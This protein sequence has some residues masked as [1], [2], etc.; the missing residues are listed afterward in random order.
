MITK[1]ITSLTVTF[2]PLTPRSA[3]RTPRLLLSLLPPAARRPGG[4]V[5]K[6]SIL[7]TSAGVDAPSS[8]TLAFRDGKE[9]KFL[10]VSRPAAKGGKTGKKVEGEVPEGVLDLGKLGI[11]DV[12]EEVDRHSRVLRRKEELGE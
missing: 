4:V 5:V 1:Y 9:L 3:H 2:N 6:T 12:V 7:P 8:V 11:K 10:E